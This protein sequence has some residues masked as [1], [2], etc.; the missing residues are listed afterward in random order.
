MNGGTSTRWRSSGDQARSAG[1]GAGAVR[2]ACRGRLRGGPGKAPV[3]VPFLP[4]QCQGMS[5]GRGW[6]LQ[7][8]LE[9]GA[10]PTAVGCARWHAKQVL[11][12]WGLTK[13]SELAELVVSELVTNAVKASQSPDWIVPIRL[14]LRSDGTRVMILVW[15]ISPQPPKRVEASD[16][17]EGGRGLILVEALCEKSGWYP[18]KELGGK[19]VW[20]LIGAESPGSPTARTASSD[21]SG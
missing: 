17:A 4:F 13:F 18:H 8:F 21:R 7:T 1:S 16:D 12:E 2:S 3:P 19:T 11:W 6:P 5:V 15:D 14:W 20:S 9:L 10:L